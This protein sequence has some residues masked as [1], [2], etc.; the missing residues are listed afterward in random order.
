MKGIGRQRQTEKTMLKP[1]DGFLASLW[2]EKS[3]GESDEE[4][5]RRKRGRYKK[6]GK[7]ENMPEN[8]ASTAVWQ[9]VKGWPNLA[10]HNV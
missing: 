8:P 1:T 9:N 3:Y 10:F 2:R 7:Q 4:K 5:E 6:K